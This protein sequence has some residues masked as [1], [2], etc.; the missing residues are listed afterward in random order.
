V[1]IVNQTGS[2]VGISVYPDDA[3]DSDT[4]LKNADAAMYEAKSSGRNGY[5]F[6]R[7]ELDNHA[8]QRL[9]IDDQ[10]DS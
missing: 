2:S 9:I 1:L 7:K 3:L 8:L 10:L 6:Y 5:Q 4:L